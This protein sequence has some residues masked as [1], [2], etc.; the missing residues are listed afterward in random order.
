MKF[1]CG[2]FQQ[3]LSGCS[4]TAGYQDEI[5]PKWLSNVQK[6]ISYF[7]ILRNFLHTARMS[8]EP[9]KA[10]QLSWTSVP[11]SIMGFNRTTWRPEMSGLCNFSVQYQSCSEKIES[12]P[13]LIYNFLK[14][15]SPIQSCPINVK[16]CIY[17]LRHE[18]K[19]QLE[20]FCL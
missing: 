3:L 6:T 13:D 20:L 9:S 2:C 18:A 7:I 11:H 12:D 8:N 10:S 1:Q 17:I 14:I 19:Q 16:S 15:I 5:P 4:N